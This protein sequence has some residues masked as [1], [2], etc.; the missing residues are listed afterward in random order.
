MGI[1][2]SVLSLICML[3]SMLV[4]KYGDY[5]NNN[6]FRKSGAVLFVVFFYFGLCYA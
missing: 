6:F 4:W 1:S 5:K 2:M 3:V